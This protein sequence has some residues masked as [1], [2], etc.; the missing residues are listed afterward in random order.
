M[1]IKGI[2]APF[3]ILCTTLGII[4]SLGKMSFLLRAIH[5]LDKLTAE[6]SLLYLTSFGIQG[7]ASNSAGKLFLSSIRK[8]RR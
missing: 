7:G 2:C 1:D 3:A 8:R 4:H 6:D 5:W